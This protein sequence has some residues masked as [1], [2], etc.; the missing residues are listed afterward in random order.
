MQGLGSR[1][2]GGLPG[3]VGGIRAASAANPMARTMKDREN[4]RVNCVSV[5]TPWILSEV[6]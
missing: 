5:E 4:N 2:V 1:R 6:Y 3:P